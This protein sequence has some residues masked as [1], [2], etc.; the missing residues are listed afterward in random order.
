MKFIVGN[1]HTGRNYQMV[2]NPHIF[3]AA[4]HIIKKG[5]GKLKE[6]KDKNTR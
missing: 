5:T 6:T 2:D 3:T 4:L 1:L